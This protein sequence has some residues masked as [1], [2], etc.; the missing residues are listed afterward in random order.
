MDG[1]PQ[2]CENVKGHEQQEGEKQEGVA[3]ERFPRARAKDKNKP[4]LLGFPQGKYR[5]GY[6]INAIQKP[7]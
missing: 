3:D 2:R 7:S 1:I 6:D 5:V 4:L